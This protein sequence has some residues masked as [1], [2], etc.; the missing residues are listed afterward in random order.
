MKRFSI[1]LSCALGALLLV[2]CGGKTCKGDQPAG[3]A[4]SDVDSVSYMMGYSFGMQMQEGNFGPLEMSGILKGMKDAAGGK[5]IDYMEFQRIVNGF[6]DK[7]REALGQEMIAKSAK[8]LDSKRGESGVDSTMTGLLYRII[9]PGEGAHPTALDTVEVNYEGK[10]LAGKVFDSSYERGVTATFP[11]GNVI[12]GWTEGIQLIGEGGT[13][14][15]F[16][17][18]DMAYGTG[19]AGKDIAP[20]EALTF[21]VDLIKIKPYRQ[22]E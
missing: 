5:Q 9:D 8:Y 16:I 6:L 20:N 2:S 3:I 13:I 22:A 1:I 18:A 7:R 19:G 11:L 21:K 15:L 14:E 10:N 17:P 12:R 4:K